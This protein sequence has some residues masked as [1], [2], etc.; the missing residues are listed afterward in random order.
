VDKDGSARPVSGGQQLKASL[1]EKLRILHRKVTKGDIRT[2]FVGSKQRQ[3]LF[4]K[5]HTPIGRPGGV[6]IFGPQ[7][8]EPPLAVLN[9]VQGLFLGHAVGTLLKTRFRKVLNPV[10]H[11]FEGFVDQLGRLFD[12]IGNA[13]NVMKGHFSFSHRELIQFLKQVCFVSR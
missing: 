9:V 5:V 6:H 7:E 12:I 8:E 10:S 2:Q 11:F 4:E 13:V 3:L 1:G